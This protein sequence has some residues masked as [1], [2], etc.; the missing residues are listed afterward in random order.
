ML[1]KRGEAYRKVWDFY[2]LFGFDVKSNFALI[3][4]FL[5]PLV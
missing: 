2:R 4:L 5:M 3:G 1:V